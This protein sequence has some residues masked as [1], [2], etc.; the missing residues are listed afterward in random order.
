MNPPL[1]GNPSPV[2]TPTH[3]R[4]P[5]TNVSPSQDTPSAGSTAAT[6][7]PPSRRLAFSEVPVIDVSPLIGHPSDA[8]ATIDNI[9][10]ACTDVGFFYITGHAVPREVIKAAMA[11]ADAFFHLP[12]QEKMVISMSDS[13]QF[14]GYMP[15]R[16]KGRATEGKNIQEGFVMMHDR[17]LG[18]HRLNGPNRW[19]R[20]PAAF[21]GSV[22]ALFREFERVSTLLID[23]FARALDIEPACFSK[24]FSTQANV[25]KIN[26]YP[27]QDAP[28]DAEIIGVRGHTD[29]DAFTILW[30]D[31]VGGLEVLNKNDEWVVVPPVQ[32]ALVI[33]IGDLMQIWSGG[34]FTSTPHRV[35]NRYGQDRYSIPMFVQPDY[36][37]EIRPLTSDAATDFEPFPA[38]DAQLARHYAIWPQR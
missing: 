24:M 3:G 26:H 31:D 27:P 15:L 29:W 33:N 21:R 23:S 28:L 1:S 38:G 32:D 5:A 25:L 16:Y 34:R 11:D 6:V 12:A 37:V 13:P 18:G 36:D 20:E 2:A 17:P 4:S 30:Q 9:R 19:P 7:L 8:D 22:G 35:I 14:R 10:R